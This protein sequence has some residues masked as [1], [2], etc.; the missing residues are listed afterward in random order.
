MYE[1]LKSREASTA[2]ELVEASVDRVFSKYLIPLI[3]NISLSE[4]IHRGREV[5]PL[6]R[7]ET[8]EKVIG[9][10]AVS[11]DGTTRMLTAAAIGKLSRRPVSA[12]PGYVVGRRRKGRDGG[13]SICAPSQFERGD[14]DARGDR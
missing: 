14:R 2:V 11:R 10:L 4:R 8:L 5:L 1:A 3:D 6:M 12:D 7:N 9:R 13:G